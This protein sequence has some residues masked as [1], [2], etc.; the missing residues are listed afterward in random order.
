MIPEPSCT[1]SGSTW[2]RAILI[3]SKYG[4][5]VLCIQGGLNGQQRCYNSGVAGYC[6]IIN[7]WET[8]NVV[9]ITRIKW[10]SHVLG[11]HPSATLDYEYKIPGKLWLFAGIDLHSG[12]ATERVSRAHIIDNFISFMK[13]L[14]LHITVKS[15]W[16]LYSTTSGCIYM[17]KKN[18]CWQCQT[19][20][21]LYSHRS[22]SRD[23]YQYINKINRS[24]IIFRWEYKWI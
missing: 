17:K 6:D 24:L 19:G 9:N 8:R 20:S 14:N 7:W 4:C 13:K 2:R 3:L 18:T 5:C 23:L 1:G 15:G 16:G 12:T 22:R 21:S 10:T 11:K